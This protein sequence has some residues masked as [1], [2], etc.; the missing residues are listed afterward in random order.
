MR[1]SSA[2]GTT[3][4]RFPHG[5]RRV[6]SQ[7]VICTSIIAD[8]FVEALKR[9]EQNGLGYLHLRSSYRPR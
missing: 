7:G 4:V 5:M 8:V 1:Q 9:S 3:L 2:R 6:F